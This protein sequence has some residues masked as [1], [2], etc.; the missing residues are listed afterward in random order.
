MATRQIGTNLAPRRPGAAGRVGATIF[1]LF[2]LVIPSLFVV[3]IAHQAWRDGRT[4]L[5]D[6]VDCTI[7]ESGVTEVGS[8]PDY[9]L[10]VKYAYAAGPVSAVEAKTR[11]GTT[12]AP[13]YKGGDDYAKAQRLALKYA[14]GSRT[15]CYVNP[16][17][18][19]DAVLVR[20]GLWVLA[21]LPI[22]LLFLA[23]GV[24]GIWYTWGRPRPKPDA[25]RPISS[26]AEG[27][28][29][30]G[31]FWFLV[32]FFSVFLI[33]GVA[34][35]AAMVGSVVR[36]VTSRGWSPVP[37]TVVSSNVRSHS[38][39]DTSY[40]VNILYAYAVGGREYRSNRY[41]FMGG[42]SSG[43][44]GKREIVDRHPPG[45]RVTAYVNP[46]DPTEA[47]IE[48]GVTPGMLLLLAP[49]LFAGVG[50]GGVYFTVR[51]AGRGAGAAP[52]APSGTAWPRN[53]GPPPQ[54]FVPSARG[55]ASA[56]SSLTLKPAQSPGVKLAVMSGIARFWNGIVSV[57]LYNVV[58]GWSSGRGEVCLTIFLVPF[59]AVGVGLIVG[60]F[61]TLLALFNPRCTVT[62]SRDDLA[63]GESVEFRWAFTGRYDRIHR[64]VLR[65]EG[66]EEATYRRGT[67]TYTDKNVFYAQDL[68]DTT[69]ATDVHSGTANWTVPADSVHS[70]ATGNNTIVWTLAVH[71]HIHGWP[72]VDEEFPLRVAPLRRPATPAM[73]GDAERQGGDDEEADD[74]VGDA[75]YTEG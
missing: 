13:G 14:P 43:Y 19:D 74:E 12:Y 62:L 16:S 53:Q 31:Q 49:L 50:A 56:R 10:S 8:D 45:T 28:T 40:S 59:V 68:V 3:F 67:S 2:W 35:T 33:V 7:L 29:S 4:W 47:V 26:N 37:A 42:S 36:G 34:V 60:M 21:M 48:R 55:P 9:A 46:D 58:T 15:V 66:R 69:R 52:G 54:R 27:A 57:F 38:G 22:P 63:L 41:N 24:G 71:G 17:N 73:Q 72:D 30:R 65:V 25:E 23:I 18:P 75:P 5:W 64:L 11:T 61:Y 20:G 70:L 32:I 6:K 44:Q 1:F 51:Q 39:E